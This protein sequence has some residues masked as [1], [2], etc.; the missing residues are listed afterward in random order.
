MSRAMTKWL[1]R[2]L[3]AVACLLVVLIIGAAVGWSMLRGRPDWYAEQPADPAAQAAAAA[4]AEEE[5]RRTIDWA[6]SQQA[7]ERRLGHAP[8]TTSASTAPA[9][10]PAA[11]RSL[12][13]RFTEQ[14]LN[15]AF[16]KWERAYRWDEKFGQYLSDPRIVLHDKRVIFAGVVKDTGTLVSLHFA[17]KM[18]PDGRARFDLKRVLGGKLPLPQ[19]AFDQHRQQ[20]EDRLKAALPALQQGARI[21]PDGS[22]NDKAVAATLSKLLLRVLAGEPDE[23]VLFLTANQGTQVPVKLTAVKVDGKAISLTVGLLNASE[24]AALLARIREPYEPA[25]PAP[26]GDDAEPLP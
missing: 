26:A 13:V 6:A 23:A 8:P 25:A 1:K 22:A 4:R 12:T 18:Q 20:L 17:P 21:A 9:T 3:V 11:T 7:E 15:A 2:L 24:R 14:E 10:N 19:S 16:T 5:L